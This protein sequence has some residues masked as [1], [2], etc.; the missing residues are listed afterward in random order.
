[1]DVIEKSLKIALDAYSE[2]KDKADKTYIL[3]PLRVMA[4]ME[5]EEAMAVALL[6]DVIEDEFY[7]DQSDPIKGIKGV[8]VDWNSKPEPDELNRLLGQAAQ[9]P[10]LSGDV[11]PSG[12]GK[13]VILTPVN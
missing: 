11:Q 7:P 8:S 13:C 5:T 6:H 10:Y 1:M 9:N 12:I 4:K 3:H 2:N